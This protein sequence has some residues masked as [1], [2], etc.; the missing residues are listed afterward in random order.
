MVSSCGTNSTSNTVSCFGTSSSSNN[1]ASCSGT[2]SKS[3]KVPDV[4]RCLERNPP[5]VN[6]TSVIRQPNA[7]RNT[8]QATVSSIHQ[9]R[10]DTPSSI[11][12]L[13]VDTPSSIHHLRA[14][15]ATSPAHQ[16]LH[17]TN[18]SNSLHS[19]FDEDPLLNKPS[20][21]RTNNPQ[22]SVFDF[23][24]F[25]PNPVDLESFH[26]RHG[27]SSDFEEI[28]PNKTEIRANIS[29]VKSAEKTPAQ[30]VFSLDDVMSPKQNPMDHVTTPTAEARAEKSAPNSARTSADAKH[31]VHRRASDAG[32]AVVCSTS[33]ALPR[34]RSSPSKLGTEHPKEHRFHRPWMSPSGQHLAPATK[35]AETQSE[36]LVKDEKHDLTSQHRDRS[37]VKQRPHPHTE[38]PDPAG[39]DQTTLNIRETFGAS[40][41]RPRKKIH[42]RL[43]FPHDDNLTPGEAP[44]TFCFPETST[45]YSQSERVLQNSEQPMRNLEADVVS[46]E[47]RAYAGAEQAGPSMLQT[48]TKR[49]RQDNEI[50]IKVKVSDVMQETREL[51]EKLEKIYQN[52]DRSCECGQVEQDVLGVAMEMFKKLCEE[53]YTGPNWHA[54]LHQINLTIKDSL[55]IAQSLRHLCRHGRRVSDV[56]QGSVLIRVKCATLTSVLDLCAMAASGE[57]QVLLWTILCCGQIKFQRGLT[58]S[59]TLDATSVRH[60]SQFLLKTLSPSVKL[61][62]SHRK[63]SP[64]SKKSGSA[65]NLVTQIQSCHHR[66]F[67]TPVLSD[68]S[69]LMSPASAQCHAKRE[70]KFSFGETAR[71]AFQELNLSDTDTP[72]S[73]IC[74]TPNS[75]VP[76][77][78]RSPKLVTSPLSRTSPLTSPLPS[79]RKGKR[80]ESIQEQE[81]IIG[82]HVTL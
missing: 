77:H 76:K 25:Q 58:L 5:A 79:P 62:P 60:C 9:L 82:D 71:R 14:D 41:D 59:V 64:T 68:Y 21:P 37:K 53:P 47:K 66:C 45:P 11:H 27:T 69:P 34:T 38:H 4:V 50:D 43:E 31:D 81:N 36:R 54:D 49:P 73:P 10:A 57:L 80:C 17:Y 2:S 22:Q 56:L 6:S 48:G 63:K 74:I 32:I 44:H 40:A 78:M 29:N 8:T 39:D 61:I 35:K 52:T 19:E 1:M 16:Q 55:D 33:S 13:R 46:R 15:N 26:N 51:G 72:T 70:R 3:S 75:H 30:C 42:R 18:F 7:S 67:S 65:E 12:Q 23:S 28:L 20:K 24:N